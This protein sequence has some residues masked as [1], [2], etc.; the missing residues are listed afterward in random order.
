MKL[1]QEIASLITARQNCYNTG[2]TEWFDRHEDA[3]QEINSLLPSGS[4]FDSGS[5]IDLQKS[6]GE[7]ICITTAFHHMNDNG[8][9]TNW[10]DHVVTVKPSLQFGFL[11]SISGK[12]FNDIKEYIVD[13]FSDVLDSDIV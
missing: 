7:K 1:Y 5:R 3:L 4:G 6:N 2:N 9:Y 11:L 13:I 10:S 8:M 12:D